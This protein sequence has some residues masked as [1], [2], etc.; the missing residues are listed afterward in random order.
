MFV[1]VGNNTDTRGITWEFFNFVKRYRLPYVRVS[2]ITVQMSDIGSKLIKDICPTNY[3]AINNAL[4]ITGFRY[5]ITCIGSAGDSTELKLVWEITNIGVNKCFFNIYN[6][7][8]RI[9]DIDTDTFTERSINVDIC[10]I[11][12]SKYAE[13]CRYFIGQGVVIKDTFTNLPSHY[14]INVIGKDKKGIGNPIYFSS[15]DRQNDGSYILIT[16]N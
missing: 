9:Y 2:N 7:Y 8:Y 11:M 12:P 10:K 4:A 16:N 5:V 15:Y 13:P 1:S 14:S 3:Y 6:L